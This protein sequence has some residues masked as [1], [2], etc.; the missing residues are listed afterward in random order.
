MK[1]LILVIGLIAVGICPALARGHHYRHM[2][3]ANSMVQGLAYGLIHMM[4]SVEGRPPDCYG[5]PWCGCYMRHI[6]GIQD[7]AYNRAPEWAHFGRP[8]GGPGVGVIVVWSHH[9]GRIV[10]GS[11]GHWEIESGN[12][13][14]R[15]AV[16]EVP[17]RGVIAYRE[18]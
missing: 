17:L 10:G 5:I 4:K 9:V 2:V 15:V 11:P 12:Y 13:N 18:P 3:I 8:A 14:N 7:K 1:K 16:A 6:Y